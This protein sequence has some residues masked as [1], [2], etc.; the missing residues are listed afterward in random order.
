MAK[1][2]KIK[3]AKKSSVVKL[4]DIKIPTDYS[5]EEDGTTQSLMQ[6][7]F[8]CRQRFVLELN[9]WAH[10]NLT[11]TTGFGS[12]F[13]DPLDSI[14]TKYMEKKK[15]TTDKELNKLLDDFVKTKR[16]QLLGLKEEEIELAKAK[17]FALLHCYMIY[18]SDDFKKNKF[19]EIES[20]FDV[21]FYEF[22]L[23]G[24]KD[25]AFTLS[26]KSWN[27]EH[28]TSGR[29]DEDRLLYKLAIDFQNQFYILADEQDP[30]IN[31]AGTIQNIIRKSQ[32]K[33]KAG[34]SVKDFQERYIDLIEADPKYFF[35][36]YEIPYTEKDKGNFMLELIDKLNVIKEFLIRKG[37][38][39][40]C[41]G[42]CDAPFPC[43][44]LE[45]CATGKLGHGYYQKKVLFEE[46]T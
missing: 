13:H 3:K 20:I 18:Y 45:A 32:H 11:R 31:K 10:T 34:E 38:I 28:K 30:R 4:S 15:L 9:R 26:K 27:I 5:F 33:M 36:R 12:M 23:R 41:Q 21:K 44:F 8:A 14:Y 43:H 24:K 46:L 2:K 29:I 42:C 16:N 17:C 6:A 1:V 40:K 19:T 39:F 7:F 22:R 37:P 35:L 25:G